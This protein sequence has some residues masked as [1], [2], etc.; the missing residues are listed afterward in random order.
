M[1]D[2]CRRA[3]IVA[4]AER[5]FLEKGYGATCTVEIAARCR[6]SKQ[7]LYRL[8]PG[9]TELFAAVVEA[10]RLRL[11]TLSDAFDDLPFEEALARIFMIDID[12]EAYEARAAYLR[13]LQ[14]E[15]VYFPELR[16]VMK[17]HGGEK[18]RADLRA[19]LDRQ[20][21][22]R[23]LLIEDTR[24]AAHMLMDMFIGSV[25]FDAVGG[26]GWDD[27]TERL[28]HFRHCITIFMRGVLPR[29]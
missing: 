3:A 11:I 5:L 24:S 6:M 25:F 7:T 12:P 10:N 4:E 19:W 1:S 18:S 13:L 26:F 23:G 14:T 8:F 15:A 16:G 29:E 21:E 2:A 22:K 17:T 27:E 20:C 9:K 28:A